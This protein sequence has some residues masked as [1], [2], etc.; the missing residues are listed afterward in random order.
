MTDFKSEKIRCSE[1]VFGSSRFDSFNPHQC[2]LNAVVVRDGKW[3]CKKHD[4]IEIKKKSEEKTK[5]WNKQWKEK[6]ENWHRDDLMKKILGKKTT[7][8]LEKMAKEMDNGL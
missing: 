5:L 1:K 2:M 8:E 3:Y 7:Q 6:E 4:P